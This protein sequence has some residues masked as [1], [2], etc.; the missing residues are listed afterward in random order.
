MFQKCEEI[1][2][3]PFPS[4]LQW[5]RVGVGG[6]SAVMFVSENQK[7]DEENKVGGR[8]EERVELEAAAG[9]KMSSSSLGVTGMER[10]GNECQVL[11]R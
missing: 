4:T 11:R 5:K 3:R 2:K 6:G 8:G 10:I 1:I 9:G 7:E